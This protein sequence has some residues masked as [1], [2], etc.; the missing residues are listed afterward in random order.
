[1]EVGQIV[2][3]K[4]GDDVRRGGGLEKEKTS[5]S[6]E[7]GGGLGRRKNSVGEREGGRKKRDI[8]DIAVKK[9]GLRG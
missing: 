9:D 1:M 5:L 4:L 6:V 2:Q 7:G 3:G 8:I